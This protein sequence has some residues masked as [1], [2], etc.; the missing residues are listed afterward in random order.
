M[1]LADRAGFALGAEAPVPGDVVTQRPQEVHPA[2]IRAV[3]LA[4]VQLGVRGLPEQEAGKSLLPRGPDH[5]IGVGLPLG[6]KV[7]GNVLDV[8]NLGQLFDRGAPAGVLLQ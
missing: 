8:E 7:L 4:E 5:Q 1:D 6:V 3:G 2:E